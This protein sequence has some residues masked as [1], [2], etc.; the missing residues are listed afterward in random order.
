M[1]KDN[2]KLD[3]IILCAILI[4]LWVCMVVVVILKHNGVMI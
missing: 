4:L 1:K 3:F 2:N